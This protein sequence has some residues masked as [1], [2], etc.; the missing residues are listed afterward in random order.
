M[1]EAASMMFFIRIGFVRRA[2]PAPLLTTIS[3]GQPMFISMKSTSHSW[4][5]SS[6]VRATVS[7]YAP[8]ICT[9][10]KSSA[11]CRLS[12]AHSEAWPYSQ[13]KFVV[14][15]WYIDPNQNKSYYHLTPPCITRSTI[16]IICFARFNH[17]V[18]QNL[19]APFSLALDYK[20][21]LLPIKKNHHVHQSTIFYLYVT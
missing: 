1:P 20:I 18:H 5:M 13:I 16:T 10:N 6:T 7:G 14:R 4:S 15:I 21:R 12:S 19:D 17:H 9:P 11:E 8:H 2:D 3:I